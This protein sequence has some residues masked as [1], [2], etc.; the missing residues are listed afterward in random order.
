MADYNSK[1]A[2]ND[3]VELIQV[4]L[5]DES[6]GAK[7]AAKEKF[8]WPVIQQKK[9]KSAGVGDKNFK[10]TGV[11]TYILVDKDGKEVV[12][13]KGQIFEKIKSL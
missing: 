13:G 12:R 8:P 9:M 7:W 1:I 5:E 2:S 10:V 4:S 3:K 11:P 6:A